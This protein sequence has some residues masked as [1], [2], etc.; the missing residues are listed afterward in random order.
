MAN[1][2]EEPGLGSITPC[3]QSPTAGSSPQGGEWHREAQLKTGIL[4]FLWSP[5]HP[6]EDK[7]ILCLGFG[8]HCCCKHCNE[9]S[10]GHS[11]CDIWAKSNAEN[12]SK[13]LLGWS[14]ATW[15]DSIITFKL[16]FF[17]HLKKRSFLLDCILT[18]NYYIAM[19]KKKAWFSNK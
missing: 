18:H 5:Q 9:S 8:R 3:L 14:T 16:S 13:C 6:G 12:L 17:F 10:S 7:K 4:L 1:R 11:P 2:E 19:K 15:V